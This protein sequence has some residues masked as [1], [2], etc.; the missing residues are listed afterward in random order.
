MTHA[1]EAWERQA[2]ACPFPGGKADGQL[3]SDLV[4]RL[5]LRL[6]QDAACQL[7]VWMLGHETVRKSRPRSWRGDRILPGHGVTADAAQAD[8]WPPAT[9]VPTR[10]PEGSHHTPYLLTP[11]G[12]I[13]AVPG[14]RAY[15]GLGFPKA[16]L[17]RGSG[18]VSAVGEGHAVLC[19]MCS[20][21]PGPPP[22]SRCQ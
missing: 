8:K 9:L 15:P 11:L 17:A 7:R 4:G 3:G 20:S 16:P 6:T 22:P 13:C 21:T 10:A 19:R 5:H 12:F 1:R 18:S 2:V 14:V